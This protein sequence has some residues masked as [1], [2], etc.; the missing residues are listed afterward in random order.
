MSVIIS[1][2]CHGIIPCGDR[3]A[4]RIPGELL[5]LGVTVSQATVSK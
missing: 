4:P 5:E 3:G 2:G 1:A